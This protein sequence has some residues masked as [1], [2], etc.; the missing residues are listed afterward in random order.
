MACT[1][2]V[3]GRH[4]KKRKGKKLIFHDVQRVAADT[5]YMGFFSHL[6]T[7]VSLHKGREDTEVSSALLERDIYVTIPSVVAFDNVEELQEDGWFGWR[8]CFRG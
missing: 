2:T 7:S 6:G 4:D 1:G 3:D 5:T 8:I